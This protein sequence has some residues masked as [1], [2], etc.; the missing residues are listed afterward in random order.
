MSAENCSDLSGAN[1]LLTGCTGL[2]GG[3]LLRRL[4]ELPVGRIYCVVRGEEQA[5]LDRIRERLCDTIDKQ[6]LDQKI[7]VV[8]GDFT[9]DELGISA[10]GRDEL[11]SNTD[12]V[13]HC[14]AITSFLQDKACWEVNFEGTRKLLGL[15][16]AFKKDIT[17]FHFGSSSTC[18]AVHDVVLFEDEFPVPGNEYFAPYAAS[19]AAVELELIPT[20]SEFDIV[21]LRPS[22]VVP[23]GAVP[24]AMI[25][26]VAWSLALMQKCSALP[27]DPEAFVDLVPLDFVGE[28]TMRIATMKRRHKCYHLTAG[29]TGTK[30]IQS[31]LEIVSESFGEDQ[32]RLIQGELWQRHFDDMSRREKMMV[33]QIS[34]YFPFINQSVIFDNSRV[35][36]EFGYQPVE[37]FD[38]ERHLPDIIR[39]ISVSEALRQSRRD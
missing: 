29:T 18:G 1:I 8:A 36:G 31:M 38:V 11:N 16:R 20:T 23:T 10:E 28:Y 15:C 13:F 17:F 39:S 35:L 37:R 12:L 34:P 3:E 24:R 5:G 22:M 6:V 33:R 2:I 26:E 30:S 32:I 27:I 19:K 14:A 7:R 9:R 25:L 4:L 21:V